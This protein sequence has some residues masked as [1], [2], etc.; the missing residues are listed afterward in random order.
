MIWVEMSSRRRSMRSLS[1]PPMGP[2]RRK[3]RVRVPCSAPTR[4]AEL[5]ISYMSQPRV[6]C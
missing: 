5:V 1:T 6:I 3:G 4:K 2:A